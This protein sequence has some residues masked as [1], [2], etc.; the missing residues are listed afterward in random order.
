MSVSRITPIKLCLKKSPLVKSEVSK[1]AK[2]FVI[3]TAGKI[4]QS[5]LYQ[6]LKR[7]LPL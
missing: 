3:T 1:E 6:S 7:A 4:T 2:N 5:D